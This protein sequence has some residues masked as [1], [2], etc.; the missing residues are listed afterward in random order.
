MKKIILLLII[1]SLLAVVS[2]FPSSNRLVV[3]RN[4][5]KDLDG[6]FDARPVES[7]GCGGNDCDD[8]VFE[9]KPGATEVCENEI[10][11]D[12]DGDDL[13]CDCGSDVDCNDCVSD[14]E[15]LKYMV[16]W[17]NEHNNPGCS[18]DPDCTDS[19]SL[20]QAMVAWKD[21]H[22]GCL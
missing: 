3:S 6:F 15:L 11:E 4:C 14:I 1:I 2:G 17:K 7:G 18:T 22:V 5:D 10:D 12:C 13:E 9:I 8:S 19:I 16:R 20:L 21:T